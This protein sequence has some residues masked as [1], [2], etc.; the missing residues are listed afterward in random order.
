[1]RRIS[2]L[3]IVL[4]LAAISAARAI[5]EK[6]YEHAYPFFPESM[7]PAMEWVN[8]ETRP[9]EPFLGLMFRSF[10]AP[11]TT[12]RTA[13]RDA[14]VGYDGPR[15]PFGG[16]GGP[17][18]GATYGFAVGKDTW[19]VVYDPVH[20]LVFYGE[21]CCAFGRDV[22]VRVRTAAPRSV[23]RRDL[24]A[25]RTARGILLG[26]TVAQVEVR[27]GSAPRTLGPTVDGRA[28]LAYW[29]SLDGKTCVE[30]RTFVF[31]RDRLEA[32]HVVRGC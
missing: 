26:M 28:A 25:M 15:G 8:R 24:S 3:A 17:G 19:R 22:L 18:D 14:L 27:E 4:I 29:S 1:M 11:A 30:E 20:R 32:V 7:R 12:N 10:R 13:V 9:D 6:D 23:P 21:S 2:I 16:T 31:R 5:S